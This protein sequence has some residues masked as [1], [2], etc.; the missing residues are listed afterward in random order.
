MENAVTNFVKTVVA[1]LTGD[2]ATETALKNEK[3][4]SSAVK[5][6]ISGL[7]SKIVDAEIK[8]Q[9]ATDSLSDAVFP[10][11]L[12]S[13]SECYTQN[14]KIA[15]QRLDSAQAELDQMKESLEYWKKLLASF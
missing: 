8:V 1:K 2:K 11:E 14:V 10:S 4:A 5:I 12:I 6:Q 13:T 15:Q 3:K 7:E 9:E